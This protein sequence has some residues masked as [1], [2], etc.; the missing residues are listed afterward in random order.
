MHVCRVHHPRLINLNVRNVVL[1]FQSRAVR[2]IHD[3]KPS[4]PRTYYLLL[5]REFLLN[6]KQLV[7]ALVN[8]NREIS[9]R[10]GEEQS[11][12]LEAIISFYNTSLG[13]LT[14][15]CGGHNRVT[16]SLSSNFQDAGMYPMIPRTALAAP[17]TPITPSL[18]GPPK[19]AVCLLQQQPRQPVH[20]HQ[21]SN[22]NP[23]HHR[24]A[25]QVSNWQPL[26]IQ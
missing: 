3:S 7:F 4:P 17:T 1:L 15:I 23:L 25:I 22:S 5:T 8:E 16:A 20:H 11:L 9:V 12:C 24:I 19:S 2:I 26:L 14:M 10:A 6:C 13:R 21:V 18:Q